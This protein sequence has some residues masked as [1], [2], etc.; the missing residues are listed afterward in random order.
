MVFTIKPR[1][2]VPGR[3]VATIEEMVL[4]TDDGADFLSAPQKELILIN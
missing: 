4:V 1:L 2:T 3:G